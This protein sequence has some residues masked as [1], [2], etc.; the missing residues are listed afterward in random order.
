MRVV[1]SSKFA[2]YVRAPVGSTPKRVYPRRLGA[3]LR[4]LLAFVDGLEHARKY[5]AVTSCDHES[6]LYELVEACADADAC[7][8]N[9]GISG[10]QPLELYTLPNDFI[11][12][13]HDKTSTWQKVKLRNLDDEIQQFRDDRGFELIAQALGVPRPQRTH[14]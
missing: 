14:D 13:H 3:S 7:G 12:E 11:R 8:G 9:D 6:A 10:E 1:K 4:E 5:A 2:L